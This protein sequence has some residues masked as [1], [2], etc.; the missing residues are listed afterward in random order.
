MEINETIARK[1]LETVGRGLVRGVG[2]P[3][4]GKMCVEA[5]VCYALGLPHGD[6]PGC[7]SSALRSLKIRLNDSDWSSDDA[8]AG[9]LKRL[10][11]AQLGSK[12]ALDDRAFVA[13]VAE[14]TIRKIVPIALREAA[15]INPTHAATLEEH[16]AKCEASGTREAAINARDAASIVRT[17]ASASAASAAAASAADAAAYASAAYAYAADYASAASAAAASAADASAADASAD[18]SASAYARDR[19]LNIFAEE[20]VQILIKMNAPGC[21]WLYLTENN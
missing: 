17:S 10:S 3:E 14:M 7:V 13:S 5:A 21:Q 18:A 4:P 16:A 8:R 12:G 6:D 1:V 20:V 19:I 9:G 2:E 11:V 15:K